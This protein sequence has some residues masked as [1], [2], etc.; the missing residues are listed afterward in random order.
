VLRR[1]EGGNIPPPLFRAPVG[2]GLAIV[3]IAFSLALATRINLR[4]A[5]TLGL[6][7]TMATAYWLVARRKRR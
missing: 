6:T 5:V 7:V 3:G 4:E 1:K 2:V